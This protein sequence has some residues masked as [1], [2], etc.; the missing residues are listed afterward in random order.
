MC[1]CVHI[2]A[3]SFY[4]RY[5]TAVTELLLCRLV[6]FLVLCSRAATGFNLGSREEREELSNVMEGPR[7]S[8]SL[9]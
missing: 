9:T 5:Q 6:P 4:C 3:V 2:R 8:L 7:D 1:V